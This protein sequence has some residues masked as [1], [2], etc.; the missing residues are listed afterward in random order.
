MWLV[1]GGSGFIGTN[2]AKFLMKNDYNFKIYDINKSKYL[3]KDVKMIIGDIRDRDKLSKAMKGCE[4]VFNLA[5]VPPSLRLPNHEIYDIDVNGTRNVLETAKENNVRRTVF[6]SS[7]SHVYGLVDK[8]S[9]PLPEDNKLN[10]INEYGRNKALAEEL[11]KKVSEE[12]DLETIVL[13]LSM[14]LGAYDF[15]PI[16][17][18]NAIPMLSNKR[19]I[20][21]GNGRGKGQSMHVNDVNTALLASA[22]ISGA[23]IHKHSIFNISGKEVLTIN[24]W[25]D[26]FKR[27][28]RSKSKVMHLPLSLA[29]CMAHIAWKLDKT[30]VH[31]SYLR[32]MAQDQYFDISK[33]KH[34]LGWEPKYTV[35]DALESTI[36]FLRKE[37]INK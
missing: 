32:L 1:I 24:E 2:F 25:I 14:V 21:A 8:G 6:T 29:K 3:P 17:L 34:I 20:M 9:C 16:L 7:A 31:P 11:C 28:S 35:V 5:T 18:E 13:R 36:E 22:E 10:P 33:A 30:K 15:D 19:V 23:S 37:Y 12:T 4:I 27:V 26:L